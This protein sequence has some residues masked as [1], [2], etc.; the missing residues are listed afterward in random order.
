MIFCSTR[1]CLLSLLRA[2]WSTSGVRVRSVD[3]QVPNAH[4]RSSW[5]SVNKS[6]LYPSQQKR[7]DRFDPINIMLTIEYTPSSG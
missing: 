1:E 3:G 6:E 2:Y 7:L 4:L 5:R